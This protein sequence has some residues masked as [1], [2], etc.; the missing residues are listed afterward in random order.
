MHNNNHVNFDSHSSSSS[1]FEDYL[2]HN[3]KNKNLNKNKIL[4]KKSRK[5][6]VDFILDYEKKNSFN[7]NF[8]RLMTS[9]IILNSKKMQPRKNSKNFDGNNNI[10]MT[11]INFID[12]KKKKIYK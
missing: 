10:G 1:G 7:K 9:D 3:H 2:K 4:K 8:K 6:G 11:N 12:G 5:R